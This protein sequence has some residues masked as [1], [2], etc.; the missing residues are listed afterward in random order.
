MV[1][2]YSDIARRSL[3][4]QWEQ[5]VI[6]PLSKLYHSNSSTLFILVVDTLDECDDE[7]DIKLVL[8]LLAKSRSLEKVQLQV[9]LTSSPEVP[10]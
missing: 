5:L 7:D 4:D 6:G 8:Y 10:I 1:R 9:F 3:G 2:E